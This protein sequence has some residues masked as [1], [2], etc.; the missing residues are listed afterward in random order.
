MLT[1]AQLNKL[2]TDSESDRIER[3]LSTK[4]MDKF[5]QAICAFSNDMPGHKTP[6]YLFIGVNDKGEVIGLQVTDKLLLDLAAIRSDGNI[7]P[8]PTMHVY[9][10]TISGKNI[11]VIEVLP[12]DLPPVRYRGRTYIRIGPRRAIASEQ[13]ERLLSERRALLTKTFD[14]RACIGS[15]LD[16]LE[17]D[18]FLSTYRKYAIAPEILEANHRDI[19]VQLASLRFFDLEKDCPTH[20]GILLF[21]KNPLY[22]LPSAYVQFVRFGG[23]SPSGAVLDEKVLSG[24]LL[25]LLRKLIDLL[26]L[27]IK[28]PLVY[29]NSLQEESRPD[30]PLVALRELLMNAVMHRS[31]EASAPIRL[32]WYDDRVE[33]QNPGGLYGEATPE[34]FPKQNTYRNL[35]IAEAMKTLGYVNRYGVG[36][37]SA[38]KA[39]LDNKNP[40]AEFQI[41]DPHYLAI[42]VWSRR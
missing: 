19:K 15:T 25:T 18:I 8:L 42:T 27:Y 29:I 30:Y 36:V 6:G 24:D 23:D 32:Y 2:L 16:D 14:A 20:A 40:P 9:K 4:D 22:Y 1:D 3:T 35:V 13:E 37:I 21:G 5:A 41:D 31:Y 33:I 38:K 39:L 26:P 28:Q 12:S 34:N 7:Q 11:V 17:L 10:K